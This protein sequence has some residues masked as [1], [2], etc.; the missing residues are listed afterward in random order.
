MRAIEDVTLDLSGLTVL[1]GENGSG[2][3]TLLDAFELMRLAATPSVFMTDVVLKYQGGLHELLRHGA[4]ELG[5]EI[6][7]DGGGPR[8]TY[9]F[10]LGFIAANASVLSERLVVDATSGTP[11]LERTT[12]QQ[13]QTFDHKTGTV[14]FFEVE[15]GS[16]A[17]PKIA[18]GLNA[19]EPLKRTAA[20]LTAIDYQVPFETRPLW[21]GQELALRTGPRWSSLLEPTSGVARYGINLA[22]CFQVLRNRGDQKWM[23]S[24]TRLAPVW[25]RIFVTSSPPLLDEATSTSKCTSV[26]PGEARPGT[27]AVRGAAQPCSSSRFSSSTSTSVASNNA[28]K[29]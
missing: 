1:I 16:L 7:I 8:L 22:N 4:K 25:A 2:K 13:G 21:Q 29:R 23:R 11:A 18:G 14:G 6:T 3:S 9:S 26:L 19:P 10:R 27:V 28:S 15:R 12:G 20:A 24:S 17:L 5:I